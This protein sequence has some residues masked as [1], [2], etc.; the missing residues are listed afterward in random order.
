MRS[1]LAQ[2]SAALAVF[3]AAPR[4]RPVI[5]D[6]FSRRLDAAIAKIRCGKEVSRAA[7]LDALQE[8]LAAMRIEK[9]DFVL[10]GG[11]DIDKTQTLRFTGAQ[12]LGE[13]RARKFTQL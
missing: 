2:M 3:E 6:D 7:V 1:Q 5:T 12:A 8:V 9:R 4:L 13:A 11:K 10:E